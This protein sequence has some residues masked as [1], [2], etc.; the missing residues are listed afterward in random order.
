M[1][2][3]GIE[4]T[5]SFQPLREG[6]K[7]QFSGSQLGHFALPGGLQGHFTREEFGEVLR[8]RAYTYAHTAET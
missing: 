3:L 5:R 6:G 1:V 8:D 7:R 2:Q 4:S